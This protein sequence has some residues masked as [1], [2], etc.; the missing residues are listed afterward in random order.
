MVRL[1]NFLG[2]EFDKLLWFKSRDLSWFKFVSF[3]GML[4]FKWLKDKFSMISFDKF[5][6]DGG[7]DFKIWL[8]LRNKIF[9]LGSFFNC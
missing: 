9:K 6:R 4:L 3:F 1:F 8:L 7:I 2:I 5:F